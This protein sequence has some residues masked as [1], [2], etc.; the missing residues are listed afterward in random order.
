MS[1]TKIS[2]LHLSVHDDETLMSTRQQIADELKSGRDVV[3]VLDEVVPRREERLTLAALALQAS[4][5]R[6]AVVTRDIARFCQMPRVMA[7]RLNVFTTTE[8]AMTWLQPETVDVR[9]T[10]RYFSLN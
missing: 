5:G 3:L 1:E 6:F 4:K 2:M 8:A 7:E 9:A 10:M